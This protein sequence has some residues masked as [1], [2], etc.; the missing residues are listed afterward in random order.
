MMTVAFGLLFRETYKGAV[1]VYEK[2]LE[3]AIAIRDWYEFIQNT[4]GAFV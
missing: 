2:I 4:T 3:G 1:V